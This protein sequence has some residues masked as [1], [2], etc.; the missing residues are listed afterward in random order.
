MLDPLTHLAWPG[1]K[2]VPWCCRDATDPIATAGTPLCYFSII[3]CR[4]K[5]VSGL[6]WSV[7]LWL[8]DL[9]THLTLEKSE[10]V[11]ND[12][13]GSSNFSS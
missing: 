8:Q 13:V 5:D 7:G 12:N 10:L 6:L 2:P 11:V 9:L 4:G 1:I 3:V